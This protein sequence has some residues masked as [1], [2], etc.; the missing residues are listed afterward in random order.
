MFVLDAQHCSFASTELI[1]FL[2]SQDMNIFISSWLLELLEARLAITCKPVFINVVAQDEDINFFIS[3]KIN[4]NPKFEH[5][6]QKYG[7]KEAMV[8]KIKE[9]SSRM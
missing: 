4:Q 1:N 3:Q 7:V 5:M 2:L 6:V 9:K 8:A